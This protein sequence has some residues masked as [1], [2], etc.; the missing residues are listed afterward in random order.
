[1]PAAGGYAEFS[2]DRGPL[3]GRAHLCAGGVW[4]DG[5]AVAIKDK[6]GSRN[7]DGE[8]GVRRPGLSYIPRI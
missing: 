1:M 6:E 5:D 4:L 8:S 7:G 2:F 3:R